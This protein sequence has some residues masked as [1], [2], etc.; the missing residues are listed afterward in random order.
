MGEQ[1]NIRCLSIE[2]FD[3]N[4]EDLASLL[5]ACVQDGASVGFVM[6]FSQDDSLS[7]WREKVRPLVANEQA[8]LMVYTLEEQIVGTVQ[9]CLATMPNQ[10]H[11]ADVSKLLVSPLFRKRGIAKSLMIELERQA[12]KYQRTLVTLDTRTGDKAEPLYH[13]LGYETVGIIPGFC[14]DTH[15]PDRLDPTTYMYKCL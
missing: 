4:I 6:P 13:K 8:V 11:R 10:M 5:V 3:K 12:Q 14:R 2:S 1:G 9:L 7:F 15:N